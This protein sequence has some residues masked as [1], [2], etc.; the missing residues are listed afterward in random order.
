MLKINER[1]GKHTRDN[2][3]E[4]CSNKTSAGVLDFLC[5]EI[6]DNGGVGGKPGSQQHTNISDIN[7]D[8]EEIENPIH[9]SGSGHQTYM[10]SALIFSLFLSQLIYLDRWFH[11]QYG[12]VGT[13]HPHQ[14]SCGN[15]RYPH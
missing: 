4:S 9:D 8:V 5:K 12:R 6:G 11:P 7:S 13:M 2:G 3:D 1:E 15:C 14:T 10:G